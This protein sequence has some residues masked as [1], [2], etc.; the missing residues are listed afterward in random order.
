MVDTEYPDSDDA[1]R[2][3]RMLGEACADALPTRLW[4][5]GIK[6]NRV[7]GRFE[8]DAKQLAQIVRFSGDPQTLLDAF[9]SCNVIETTSESNVFRICG[10]KRNARY[11]KERDR[12]RQHAS[13]KK[14]RVDHAS[15]TKKPR[16]NHKDPSSSSSSSS[17]KEGEGETAQVASGGI[18][19]QVH[20][21]FE[22]RPGLAPGHPDVQFFEADY[23]QRFGGGQFTKLER[24]DAANLI[25]Q[26]VD[27]G[28]TW[29]ALL[30]T[31][32]T[33]F[34]TR[35]GS[36]SWLKFQ[37]RDVIRET[38]GKPNGPKKTRAEQNAEYNAKRDARFAREEAEAL[39]AHN[40]ERAKEVANGGAA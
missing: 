25:R 4:C 40:R 34:P 18:S 33:K 21:E 20:R 2:L 36:L 15:D 11:F 14:P 35:K 12:L 27:S 23:R 19:E 37:A 6:T 17:S 30:E 10:W 29:Q 24:G 7:T 13:T 32:A 1:L 31:Y 16:V 9:L 28:V 39:E 38:P 5:W 26:C 22:D 8:A 3:C